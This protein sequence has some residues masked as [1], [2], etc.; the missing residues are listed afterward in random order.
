[1]SELNVHPE[2]VQKKLWADHIENDEFWFDV[3]VG[4]DISI[5]V[6]SS[7]LQAEKGLELDRA[8]LLA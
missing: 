3:G 8:S 4:G 7:D 6:G 5:Q 1:M 2:K